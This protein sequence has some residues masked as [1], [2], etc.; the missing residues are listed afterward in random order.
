MGS[1]PRGGQAAAGLTLTTRQAH[2]GFH[3]TRMP[4]SG[5][6]H[7]HHTPLHIQ[8]QRRRLTGTLDDSHVPLVACCVIILRNCHSSMALVLLG[9]QLIAV[10]R[11]AKRTLCSAPVGPFRMLFT[12]D[13]LSR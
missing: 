5:G 2:P 8:G 4:A 7:R 9:A 1:R 11:N 10:P 13:V 6:P 3:C 12:S